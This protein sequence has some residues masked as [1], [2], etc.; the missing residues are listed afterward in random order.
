MHVQ[1]MERYPYNAVV[2]AQYVS[3]EHRYGL[4]HRVRAYWERTWEG[5]ALFGG[6]SSAG[7]SPGLVMV[8]AQFEMQRGAGAR[9]V[10]LVE[11]AV[12]VVVCVSLSRDWLCQGYRVWSITDTHTHTCAYRCSGGRRGCARPCG[13]C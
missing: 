7:P 3:L 6:G 5:G 8:M 13:G 9:A 4:S 2:F 11:R 1:V 12:C 10:A